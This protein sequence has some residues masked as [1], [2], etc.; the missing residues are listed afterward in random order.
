MR[1]SSYRFRA[2]RKLVNRYVI[3][4]GPRLYIV[5]AHRATVT[6]TETTNGT[7]YTIS[8]VNY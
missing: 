5:R 2:A 4:N 1:P 8:V 6:V 7:S 3:H